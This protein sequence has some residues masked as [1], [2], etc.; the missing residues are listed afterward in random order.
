V[1]IS[2]GPLAGIGVLITRPAR[3]AAG[4]A[5]KIAA[6]GGTPVI[7]PTIVILPPPDRGPLE[8][9]HAALATY[10]FAFFVSAN[11]MARPTRGWPAGLVAFAPGPAPP[12]RWPHRRWWCPHPDDNVR[13]RRPVALPE[14][15]AFAASVRSSSAVMAAREH[16]AYARRA[17]RARRLCC[18]LSAR[19]TGKR[20]PGADGSLRRRPHPRGHHHVERGAGQSLGTGGRC[21]AFGLARMPDLRSASAHRGARA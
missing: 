4:F 5:Q 14:L 9:A 11:V 6:L 20:R 12:R 7:F 17:R 13:Q 19:E 1:S 8:R 2:K 10:D 15:V 21:D 18:L 3:Q 16:W